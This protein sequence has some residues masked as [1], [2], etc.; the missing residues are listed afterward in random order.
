MQDY[1]NTQNG[2]VA[3]ISV[4]IISSIIVMVALTLS[5]SSFYERYN[6]LASELKER[7][8]S[9][10]EACA[11]EGLLL[12]ANNKAH[13]TTSTIAFNSMDSC[14]LGP[15]PSSGNPRILFVTANTGNYFTNLKINV[16][17]TTLLVNSWEEIATY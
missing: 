9:N 5:T 11:D 4:V 13:L 16:D 17:P 7:S 6:I 3:L 1:K 14:T 15:I 8:L 12:I 2:F 10:A